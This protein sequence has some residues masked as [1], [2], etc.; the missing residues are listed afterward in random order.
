MLD[1]ESVS[2]AELLLFD[3]ILDDMLRARQNLALLRAKQFT[4]DY[5]RMRKQAI[6]AGRKPTPLAKPNRPPAGTDE[7]LTG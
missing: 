5:D 3:T 4:R 1:P 7:R 6:A 2:S